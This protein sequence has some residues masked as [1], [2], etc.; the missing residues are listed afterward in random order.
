MHK[1][2]KHGSTLCAFLISSIDFCIAQAIRQLPAKTASTSPL[3][4]LLITEGF[5]TPP[6]KSSRAH[7]RLTL[8]G[9]IVPS[10][11]QSGDP[12]LACSALAALTFFTYRCLHRLSFVH[13]LC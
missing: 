12:A 2:A 8:R 11:P 7:C 9:P 6:M 3:V 4:I 5:D 10:T 1:L 13:M